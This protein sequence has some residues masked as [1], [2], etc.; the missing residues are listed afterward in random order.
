MQ[1]WPNSWASAL[2]HEQDLQWIELPS[3]AAPP[4]AAALRAAPAL[5]SL[6]W[7]PRL[8][9]SPVR[10]SSTPSA[11]PRV[12]ARL[13]QAGLGAAMPG[14]KMGPGIVMAA[15]SFGHTPVVRKPPTVVHALAAGGA[16]KSPSPKPRA[17]PGADPMPE[18]WSGWEGG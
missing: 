14:S 6:V 4:A 15:N 10:S 13:P 5:G 3:T 16:G 2:P 1:G 17:L 8:E 12:V 11:A 9:A 18:L 7:A